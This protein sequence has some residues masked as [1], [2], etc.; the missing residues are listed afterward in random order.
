MIHAVVIAPAANKVLL[1]CPVHV[2]QKLFVWVASVEGRGLEEVRRQSGWH[3]E[4]L[5]G[6]RRGQRSIRLNIQWRAIYVVLTDGS[7][8]FCEVQEVTPHDY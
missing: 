3:D 7:I 8:E 1:K 5:Q 4:P 2:R 6:Q